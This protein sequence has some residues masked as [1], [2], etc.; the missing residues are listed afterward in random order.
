MK[1]FKEMA[2]NLIFGKKGTLS[3]RRITFFLLFLNVITAAAVSIYIPC[4]KKMAIDLHTT[5]TVMQMTIVAH[6]IGEFS[7]RVLCGPII[8][9]YG[10]RAVILPSLMI[11]IVGHLGCMISES[12]SMFMVMRFIQ[13]IG[14][15]VIYI[16][17]QNIIG[18]TFNEKEKSSVIGIFELYQPIAWILS[19]F[20]GSI[21]TQISNWR[22]FFFLLA[23]AHVVGLLF[24]WMYPAKER[25]PVQKRFLILKF[26]HEYA[27]LLKNYSF[28]IYALI[29]GLFAGG[30]MI[31]ATSSTLICHKFFGNNSSV[32]AIFAAIPLFFYVF[33]TFAYRI[34]VDKFGVVASRRIGTCVYGI[35]GIYIMY[36]AMHKSPWTPGILLTLMCLQCVGSAFLVPVSVLK[37]LQSAHNSTCAGALTVVIFRN[38]IMSICI[39]AAAKFNSSI[40]TVMS[41]VFMTVATILLLMTTRK[42]IKTR[43]NRKRKRN[44]TIV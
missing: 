35:F 44:G 43:A 4:L 34:I 7:G 3:N 36:I 29:P 23:L 6:L 22:V 37:A 20:V 15:S 38:I 9:L 16:I 5:S 2:K 27:N 32:V 31:F 13:A 40:T 11:S 24:F 14:S 42:I 17:S 8:E 28:V 41:C 26:L 19:P 33:A 10:N 18:E 25:Q 30:Y 1:S 12:S 39:T 21:L